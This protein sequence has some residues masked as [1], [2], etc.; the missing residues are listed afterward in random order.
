ME[1]YLL[2]IKELIKLKKVSQAELADLIKKNRMTVNNYLT[3]NT[4]IDVETLLDI[5][6]AL[7][8]NPS[9]FFKDYHVIYNNLEHIGNNGLSQ[10]QEA[11]GNKNSTF[12]Q[13]NNGSVNYKTQSED[14]YK[15]IMHLKKEIE[16]KN[17][18]I[19]TQRELIEQLKK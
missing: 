1:E 15:E 17:E 8:V 19:K 11:N 12:I 16:S 7:E 4:K 14:M 9:V 18:I 10:V 5:A 13:T 2:K 6:K 3:G